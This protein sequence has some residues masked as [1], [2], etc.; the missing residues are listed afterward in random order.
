MGKTVQNK[1]TVVGCPFCGEIPEVRDDAGW[2]QTD[3]V[4]KNPDCSC[5][6]DLM[7]CGNN[8]EDAAARWN[9]RHLGAQ[10]EAS[11]GEEIDRLEAEIVALKA[12]LYD[13]AEATT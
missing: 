9:R 11:R 7:V 13:K 10:I 5:D 12:K 4:C 8:I 6:G 2:G 1:V 3:I